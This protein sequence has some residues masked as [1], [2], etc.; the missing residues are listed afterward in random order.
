VTETAAMLHNIMTE[1][2]PSIF[3][4]FNHPY[5]LQCFAFHEIRNRETCLSRRKESLNLDSLT[6]RMGPIGCPETSVRNYHYLLRN[7]PEER[8]SRVINKIV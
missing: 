4:R 7:D 5:S 1:K 3:I 2:L 6:L 8:S